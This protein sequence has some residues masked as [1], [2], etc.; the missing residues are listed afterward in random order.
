MQNPSK[1]SQSALEI[2][3]ALALSRRTSLPIINKMTIASNEKGI[4]F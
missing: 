4:S 1:T 3:F 2:T